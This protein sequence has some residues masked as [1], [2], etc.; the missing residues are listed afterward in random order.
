[1]GAMAIHRGRDMAGT[2][3]V[4]VERT[5][6]ASDGGI[7][8]YQPEER[9]EVSAPPSRIGDSYLDSEEEAKLDAE[10]EARRQRLIESVVRVETPDPDTAGLDDPL[11]SGINLAVGVAGCRKAAEQ[12]RDIEFFRRLHEDGKREDQDLGERLRIGPVMAILLREIERRR[13]LAGGA[14]CK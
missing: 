9:L 13:F 14:S 3:R 11:H 1:M 6:N 8:I 2:Q 7:R 4:D 10:F 12:R 5:N